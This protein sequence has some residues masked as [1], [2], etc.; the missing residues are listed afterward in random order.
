MNSQF[1]HLCKGY[2]DDFKERNIN[3]WEMLFFGLNFL[4]EGAIDQ[5]FDKQFCFIF[6]SSDVRIKKGKLFIF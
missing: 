4:V 2:H 3:S 1:F 6:E 5:Q